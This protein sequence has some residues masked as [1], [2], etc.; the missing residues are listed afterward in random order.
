MR[1]SWLEG[2]FLARMITFSFNIQAGTYI[3][4]LVDYFGGGFIIYGKNRQI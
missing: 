2:I 4:D 3:L 1:C